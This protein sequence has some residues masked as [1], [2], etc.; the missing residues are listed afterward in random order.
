MPPPRYID[1]P[2]LDHVAF[3]YASQRGLDI[4][5]SDPTGAHRALEILLDTLPPYVRA[6][7][8]DWPSV[9]KAYCRATG[10]SD[11]RADLRQGGYWVRWLARQGLAIGDVIAA[12]RAEQLRDGLNEVAARFHGFS[13]PPNQQVWRRRGWAG[14]NNTAKALVLTALP[15][16][17][18]LLDVKATRPREAMRERTRTSNRARYQ[19]KSR[20]ERAELIANMRR[21]RERGRRELR[22][23]ARRS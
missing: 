12:P 18:V 4:R 17:A 13:V 22:K 23:G 14:M 2:S 1:L 3:A 15:H 7:V 21:R 6:G 9:R 20:Q 19:A 8:R 11:P 5:L 10:R 16:G